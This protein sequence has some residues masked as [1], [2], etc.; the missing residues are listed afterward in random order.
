[1]KKIKATITD[2][3]EKAFNEIMYSL[4]KNKDGTGMCTQS[5]AVGYAFTTIGLFEK[6]MG[7]DIITFLN[8]KKEQSEPTYEE[9]EKKAKEF[10]PEDLYVDHCGYDSVEDRNILKRQTLINGI[11]I[12][13]DW[14]K[15]LT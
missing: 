8:E 2:D 9:I 13:L 15:Q 4:P 3:A 1:M 6:I 12:G 10:I 11:K 5:Q 14:K 7:C